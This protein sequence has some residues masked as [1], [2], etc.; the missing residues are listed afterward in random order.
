MNCPKCRFEQVDTN[1]ECVRCG[2]VFEKYY[3]RRKPEPDLPSPDLGPVVAETED[4]PARQ[5]F[6]LKDFLFDVE[7]ET[8][9]LYF[10]GRA[11]LFVLLLVWGVKMILSPFAANYTMSS[12]MHLVNLPFHE[13]G[14]L[15]FRLF[16]QWVMSLGGTLFQLLMPAICMGVF[17]LKVRDVFGASV[18]MWWVGE[19]FLDI[20]P[21]INDA[22]A[23][24]LP[25]LGGNT[26]ET[27]PYGFHD[28]E[29]IL[30][31][32]NL[33]RYDHLLAQ[34]SVALGVILFLASFG[35]GG[36]VLFKQYRCLHSRSA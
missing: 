18:C 36:Y 22:R 19:N 29:Y 13:A 27:S 28:W 2:L 17:L 26:G 11:L 33:L 24:Q 23:L 4:K 16:G 10:G 8:N 34:G 35:W 7:I 15:I 12:F 30:N 31:E 32:V 14:H 5:Q 20:A 6:S 25:L 3:R 1:T 9:P 21:Y